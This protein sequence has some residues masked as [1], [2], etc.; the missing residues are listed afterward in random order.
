MMIVSPEFGEGPEWMDLLQPNPN[1]EKVDN[2]F[3][4]DFGR[5]NARCVYSVSVCTTS[6]IF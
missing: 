2:D 5:H 1:Y 3:S 4:I 6:S